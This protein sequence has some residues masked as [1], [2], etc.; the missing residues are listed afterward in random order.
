MDYPIYNIYKLYYNN[1][2]TNIYMNINLY[3]LLYQIKW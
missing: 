2:N 1:V 3:F